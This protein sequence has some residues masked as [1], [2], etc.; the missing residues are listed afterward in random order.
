[1]FKVAAPFSKLIIYGRLSSEETSF[2]YGTVIYKNL[3]I[4]GFGIDHWLNSKSKDKLN[5]IWQ[6]LTTAIRNNTLK[7]Q[8]D[9]LFDLKDFKDAIIFYKGTGGKVILK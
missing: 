8:S 7:L 6:E 1:M 9:K 5:L 4:E 2:P 3:K